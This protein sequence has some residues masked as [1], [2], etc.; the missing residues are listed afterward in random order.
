MKKSVGLRLST[1]AIRR[2][3]LVQFLGA[4]DN[5][6]LTF[7]RDA[8]FHLQYT[9]AMLIREGVRSFR[10]VIWRVLLISASLL[11]PCFWHKRIEAGDLPSH[12]YNAWL[13][14]L[15]ARGQAPGLYVES[16]GIMFCPT[17][18]WRNWGRSPDLLSLNTSSSLWQY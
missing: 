6:T 1:S 11:L 10:A 2:R 7:V 13:S 8:G 9:P 16:A 17:S 3:S 5:E 14:Q 4:R 18:R 12:T 15:I